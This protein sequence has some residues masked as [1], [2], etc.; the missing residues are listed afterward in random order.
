[1]LNNS[2]PVRASRQGCLRA[3][4]DFRLALGVAFAASMSAHALGAQQSTGSIAVSDPWSIDA[5]YLQL[6]SRA[7]VRHTTPSLGVVLSKEVSGPGALGLLA[8]RA[9][10]GWLRAVRQATTAQG[11]TLGV[12]ADLGLPGES[13]ASPRLILRPGIAVLAGW[14]EAQDSVALYP[15]RGAA[16]TADAGTAG[17]QFSW[18]TTRG[19]TFGVGVSLGAELRVSS[20][21]GVSASIRHWSFNGD[22]VAPNRSLTLLGVGIAVHPQALARD[23]RGWLSALK[24]SPNRAA[25]A[26]TRSLR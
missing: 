15:Y 14:A 25:E 16:G 4:V 22:V 23:A 5:Q 19:R 10:A 13:S 7:L 11:A 6:N 9:E 12:A 20:A 21:F 8:W 26:T 17:T 18:F 24:G 2:R 1:M 3:V